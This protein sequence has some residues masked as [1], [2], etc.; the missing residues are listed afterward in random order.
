[1]WR[2]LA[3]VAPKQLIRRHNF[4]IWLLIANVAIFVFIDCFF[5]YLR[6]L[7]KAPASLISSGR[8]EAYC[9]SCR[10]PLR[11]QK[12]DLTKHV[13]TQMH[14]KNMESLNVKKQVTLL[15]IGT[16]NVNEASKLAGIKLVLNNA[17][18]GSL[19]NIDHLCEMLKDIDKSSQL[20]KLRLHRTKC[21]KI[22]LNV[23]APGI[24]KELLD[25]LGEESYS[26]LLD[27][28]TDVSTMK[29]MAYCI[30]YYSKKQKRLLPTFWVLVLMVPVIFVV[31]I[32]VYTYYEKKN[33]TEYSLNLVAA[34]ASE[35]SPSNIEFLLQNSRNWFAH[36]SLRLNTY[37]DLYEKMNAGKKP[38]KLVQLAPTRWL[39]LAGA[40]TSNLK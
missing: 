37:H 11:A 39:A 36:S 23:I 25:D 9:K 28:S 24:L 6:W 20:T 14:I 40:V 33:I 13:K 3:I 16:A 27:E 7:C 2:F 19:K 30:R 21:S 4:T 5:K 18:H 12:H 10:V 26:I 34:K 32:T 8:G 35:Q 31:S 38:S 17:A 22:I 15:S 1:M 29:Y